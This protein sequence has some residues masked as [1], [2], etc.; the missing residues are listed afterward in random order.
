M[1]PIASH[2]AVE[3]EDGAAFGKRVALLPAEERAT[4]L[5]ARL[6]LMAEVWPEAAEFLGILPAK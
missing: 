5:E 4:E 6:D 1:P 2:A 3:V